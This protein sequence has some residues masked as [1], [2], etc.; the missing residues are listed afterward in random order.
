LKRSELESRTGLSPEVLDFVLKSL[1][2]EK[3]LE[4]AGELVRVFGS[5]PGIGDDDRRLSDEIAK[6]Y[7][8]AGLTVP[9][10]QTVG[11]R[12]GLKEAELR[13]LITLLLR[14]KT[15]IKLSGDDLYMHKNV[16]AE[17]YAR[18]R[19]LRGQ[20]VDI[21]RFKEVAGVSRK[22]AIPLLEHLDRERITRRVGEERLV[23]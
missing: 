1:A 15:L 3:K 5:G 7:F 11:E 18:I 21:A 4:L 8:S 2:T 17:L 10:L 13:R 12:L 6:L 16:M 22:Y 19:S 9:L 14:D 20:T 23:L